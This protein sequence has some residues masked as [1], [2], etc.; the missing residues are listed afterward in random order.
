ML[1][2][3]VR[4]VGGYVAYY[5]PD[6][7]V[8]LSNEFLARHC[9]RLLRG[10]EGLLGLGFDPLPEQRSRPDISGTMW[11]D[12]R[13]GELRSLSYRYQNLGLG[14]STEHLGGEV[15]FARLSSGAWIVRS[16]AIRTPVLD[17][18]PPRRNLAGRP[19]PPRTVLRGID[20]GGGHVT[21]VWMTGHLA[22]SVSTDTLP[23]RPPADSLI[24][25]FP[26][27]LR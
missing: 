21:S 20:E 27:S 2:G 6:A 17:R 24:D 3:F 23:V 14:V 19:L 26:L 15:A 12:P 18:G 10:D 5:A 22:G 9:F 11:L 8:L 13:S 16:W 1:G 4:S 7:E 25:R